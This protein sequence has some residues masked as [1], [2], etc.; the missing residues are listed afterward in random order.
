M[1]NTVIVE[2]KSLIVHQSG[3]WKGILHVPG[4]KSIS[5][6]SLI[7]GAMS[8][9]KTI[10]Q[11]LLMGEDVLATL[12]ACQALGADIRFDATQKECYVEGTGVGGFQTPDN[13][14]DMGNSG[15]STRLLLGAIATQNIEIFLTGDQS[16]RKRPMGRVITP[17]SQMGAQIYARA[18]N[19][20][21]LYMKG[22]KHALPICYKLPVPSAQVKSAILLAGLNTPGITTVIEPNF[23]RDHTEI[24]LESFG[25]KLSIE[26]DKDNLLRHISLKGYA[27]LRAPL[28]P[29]LV[30]NDP[31]SAA[32]Y[33]AAATLIP[34]SRIE[35]P[36]ICLNE[37]R[38]AF[39]DCLNAMGGHIH[40]AN[41][42]LSQGEWVGD[43]HIEAN[44][45]QGI[46]IAPDMVPKMID[47]IPILSV[48]AACA[49]GKTFIPNLAELRVKES[50][51]LRAI[52]QN[53][54]A[55][56]VEVQAQDDSLTIFGQGTPPIGGAMIKTFFDH[57]IAMSF[58]ILGMVSQQP[59]TI[60]D[61]SMIKTSFPNFFDGLKQQNV[62]IEH[63]EETTL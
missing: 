7:L 11:N 15:T 56:Q 57:R 52:A 4:D 58:I 3:P 63:I 42:R 17:L 18:G 49:K 44:A 50:D 16:L 28:Q 24:M 38:F 33:A 20:L 43:I 12:R 2:K 60:D 61:T 13:M 45:L 26:E 8:R 31:S 40:I 47:E 30:P 41:K 29:I 35:L 1:N 6:R 14:L 53:L 22:A 55:C 27:D 32:F 51:R 46:E 59:I 62:T 21:P 25:A 48:L 10:I 19:L 37:K 23:L 5:H 36:N 54:Q 39:F 9:G 34:G